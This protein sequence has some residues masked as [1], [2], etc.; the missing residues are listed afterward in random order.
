M[1]VEMRRG[2]VL[3]PSSTTNGCLASSDGHRLEGSRGVAEVAL[4]EDQVA[5]LLLLEHS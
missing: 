2:R 5:S 1:T 4:A 3:M